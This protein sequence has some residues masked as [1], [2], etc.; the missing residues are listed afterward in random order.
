MQSNPKQKKYYDHMEI[1][2]CQFCE[3]EFSDDL[4]YELHENECCKQFYLI[5]KKEKKNKCCIIS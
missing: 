2:V 1:F 5:D 3:R 4:I